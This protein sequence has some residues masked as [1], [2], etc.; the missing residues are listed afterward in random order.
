MKRL[1]HWFERALWGS[2]LMAVLAVVCGVVLALAAFYLGTVDV[3]LLLQKLEGYANPALTEMARHALRES[4]VTGIVKAVDAYLIGAIMLIFALGF[5]ELFVNRI[6][7]AHRD[8]IGP[9]LLEFHSVDDLKDRIARLILLVLVIEYFQYALK[10]KFNTAT[11]LLSLA[12]GVMFIGGALYLS[13][14]GTKTKDETAPPAATES[15]QGENDNGRNQAAGR[16]HLG[17]NTLSGSGVGRHR[18]GLSDGT[19]HGPQNDSPSNRAAAGGAAG[20]DDRS[21]DGAR[22]HDA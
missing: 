9:R 20:D 3:V 11:D 2:R 15:P 19:A 13:S 18:A 16:A 4:I 12:L 1:E 22:G 5:Y 21:G 10:L 14:L 7:Q 6:E 17:A 8:K